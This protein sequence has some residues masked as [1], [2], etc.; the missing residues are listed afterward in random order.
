MWTQS[1]KVAPAPGKSTPTCCPRTSQSKCTDLILAAWPGGAADVTSLS[2]PQILGNRH[3][4]VKLPKLLLKAHFT[5]GCIQTS[6][7][8][9]FGEVRWKKERRGQ[10]RKGIVAK[11]G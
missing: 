10:K 7:D 5:M 2:D 4:P 8:K 3:L 6:E 1:A 11:A 9:A